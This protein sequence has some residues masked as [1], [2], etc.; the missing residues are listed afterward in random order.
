MILDKRKLVFKA[1]Y[2]KGDIVSSINELL[3]I[4]RDNY[5]NLE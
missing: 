2:K 5:R 4:I 1:F 3:G